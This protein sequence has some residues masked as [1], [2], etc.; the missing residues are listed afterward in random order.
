MPT[1]PGT[2]RRR[3]PRWRIASTY[4]RMWRCWT[5]KTPHLYPSCSVLAC[6]GDTRLASLLIR[7]LTGHV[8]RRV[9]V[10]RHV[11]VGEEGE[12]SA[13]SSLPPV[14][15]NLPRAQAPQPRGIDEAA[16]AWPHHC[17]ALGNQR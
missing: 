8:R 12:P 7:T 5:D 16:V 6:K 17:G 14:P 1:A 11:S 10:T 15:A 4:Y 2:G 3:P 13:P 9:Q